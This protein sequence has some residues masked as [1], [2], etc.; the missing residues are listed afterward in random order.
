MKA[1]FYVFVFLML[2]PFVLTMAQTADPQQDVD[3]EFGM[4]EETDDNGF[5]VYNYFL[6]N[7]SDDKMFFFDFQMS[8][9]GYEYEVLKSHPPD[10]LILGPYEKMVFFRCR[11][12][13]GYP[14]FTWNAEF[15]VYE[16]ASPDYPRKNRD[17]IFY[18]TYF[19]R[20][21]VLDYL[22]YIK[23]ISDETIR[24]YDFIL[25]G[26]VPPFTET[27][28]LPDG[29]VYLGPG[30]YKPVFGFT[31]SEDG[32]A[33][34][35]EWYARFQEAEKIYEI[36]N[37]S[38]CEGIKK[39]IHSTGEE[40]MGTVKGNLTESTDFIDYYECTIHIEGMTR[41]E[42][43]FFLISYDFASEIGM[44]A[45]FEE[46]H[47]RFEEYR[48][49]FKE[50]LP[51]DGSESIVW[52]GEGDLFKIKAVYEGELDG[53]PYY[54]ETKVSSDYSADDDYVLEVSIQEA[55]W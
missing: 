44:P 36:Q 17:Y 45:P 38:F 26:E 51:S 40:E 3:Y 30:E 43:Q 22:Y 21:G 28:A 31:I 54:I 32:D 6:K 14:G 18:Y 35:L 16:D 34:Y 2:A 20:Y 19:E 52:G 39:V 42:V 29:P 53:I 41:E 10:V 11:S 5:R 25:G 33:P 49:K 4:D 12:I 24:F 55:T 23:N 27:S 37:Y 15:L 9:E 46:V 13:T 48:L 8:D 1:N 7:L 47:S 50:C